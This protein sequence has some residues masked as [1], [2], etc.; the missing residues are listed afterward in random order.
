MTRRASFL[1]AVLG[2]AGAKALTALADSSELVDAVLTPR[3]AMAWLHASSS[4]NGTVP[5]LPDTALTL[6]KTET[7]YTGEV[8][9]AAGNHVFTST[10]IEHVAAAITLA[11]GEPV[12][13]RPG[14]R[15]V[16]LARLGKTLD[17]LAKAQVSPL[18]RSEGGK[19][20][21]AQARTPKAP[22]APTAKAPT[23]TRKKPKL[24]RAPGGVKAASTPKPLKLSE[25]EAR[26]PCSVCLVSQ[27]K[28]AEVQLCYCLRDLR[29]GLYA[30]PLS[31]GGFE[32]TF[33]GDWDTDAV[34]V[35]LEAVG[36]K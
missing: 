35:L 27:F 9:L 25:A 2:K 13:A 28:G 29:K 22:E 16:D 7:G 21:A 32:L 26:K 24:P 15:D 23:T 12:A 31:K 17:L 3:A 8:R 20:V 33:G 10:A 30:V 6:V 18:A 19:G 14:L 36:R 4:H 5:G 1:V 11:V 34:L